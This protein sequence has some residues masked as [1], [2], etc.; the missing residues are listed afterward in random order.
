MTLEMSTGKTFE[1]DWIGGPT[2]TS[3][4]VIMQ[5]RDARSIAA[6]AQDVEGVQTMTRRS[7]TEGDATYEGYTVVAS[8]VRQPGGM[9]QVAFERPEGGDGA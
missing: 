8:I 9:V 2:R 1:V 7:D 6:I 4:A 3:G 5:M